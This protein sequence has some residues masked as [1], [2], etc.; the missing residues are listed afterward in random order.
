MRG[1]WVPKKTEPD[2]AKPHLHISKS[3]WTWRLYDW[4]GPVGPI[5]WKWQQPNMFWGPLKKGFSFGISAS[6]RI[7]QGSHCHLYAEFF[8]GLLETGFEDKR[9]EYVKPLLIVNFKKYPSKEFCMLF[10]CFDLLE[11][12]KNAKKNKQVNCWFSNV[13]VAITVIIFW[14]SNSW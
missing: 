1:Q 9:G 13:M 14:A 7:G 6:I 10:D 3:P 11:I 8:T 5:Q 12:F 4:I 2:G